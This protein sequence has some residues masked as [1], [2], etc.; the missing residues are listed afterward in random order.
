MTPLAIGVLLFVGIVAATYALFAHFEERTTVRA[1]LR[2]LDGYDV[3]TN[4]REKQLLG[5]ARQRIAAPVLGGLIGLGKRFTP[6]GYVDKTKKKLIVSGK[7][8]PTD[9]DRFLPV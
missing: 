5:S 9:H 1:S 6:V 7:H 2:Q 8:D 3:I 4:L